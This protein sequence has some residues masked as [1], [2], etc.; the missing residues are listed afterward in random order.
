[1]K[2]NTNIEDKDEFLMD[3]YARKNAAEKVLLWV[4]AISIGLSLVAFVLFIAGL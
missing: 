1:M 3:V 4:I 2:Y